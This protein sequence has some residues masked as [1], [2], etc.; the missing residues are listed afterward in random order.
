MK[1]IEGGLSIDD[2][3][4][5]RYVND[6]NFRR[7]KRFYMVENNLVDLVRGW[8]GHKQESKY[9]FVTSGIALI[10]VVKI[11]NWDK[12]SKDLEVRKFI[13]VAGRPK[14]LCIRPGCANAFKSLKKDT[15]VIFFSS[16]TL[17]ESEADSFNFSP[18]YW[19]L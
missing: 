15:R 2:R 1:I 5:V 8:H 18:D 3:G 6:F 16:S 17:E 11:D 10:G 19:S 14:I 13:L 9:V 7:V 12:P 4:V